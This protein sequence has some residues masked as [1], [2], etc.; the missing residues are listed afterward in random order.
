MLSRLVRRGKDTLLIQR[1]L[2]PAARRLTLA[3]TATALAALVIVA[4]GFAG[5]E[6]PAFT[7]IAGSATIEIKEL[8]EY[9]PRFI[10][11]KTVY[12][13]Q[14]LRIV[15]KTPAK[16]MGPHTFSLVEASTLPKT[17][18]ARKHCFTP[19]HICMAI[20]KWH[21]VKGNGPPTINPAEAGAEGWDTEGSL[22]AKGDSWFT[23]SK[24]GASFEQVVSAKAGETIHFMCAIHPWMQGSVE[25]API[26]PAPVP[27]TP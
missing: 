10:G 15:N 25:V 24:K 20:A 9:K 19:D 17:P 12:E 14:T 26:P 27:P 18:P 7:S 2:R 11:P 3:V 16:R 13:G 8:K 23:G 5:A 21:G 4:P 1:H 22:T 6:T